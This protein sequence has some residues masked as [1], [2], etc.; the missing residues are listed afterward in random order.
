MEVLEQVENELCVEERN[1]SLRGHPPERRADPRYPVNEDA[2]LQVVGCGLPV[3]GSIVDLSQEGCRVRTRER[4]STRSRWPVEVIFKVTGVVFQFSGV[5][6]WNDG[7]NRLGI[8]FVNMIPRH[9]V[10]LAQIINGMA[11]AAARAEAVNKLVRAR[12]SGGPKGKRKESTERQNREPARMEPKWIAATN[13]DGS[14]GCSRGSGPQRCQTTR[15][16]PPGASRGRHVC[17]DSPRQC[18]LCT[19]RTDPRS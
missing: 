19:A 17:E 5:V 13:R 9:T 16:P 3:P 11:V 10:E 12:G 15:S 8:H 4:L 18:G 1:Q 6:G 14:S 7:R 2:M